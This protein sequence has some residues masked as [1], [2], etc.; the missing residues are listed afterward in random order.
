MIH[1]IYL[2]IIAFMFYWLLK[3]YS[4]ANKKHKETERVNKF[5]E[6]YRKSFI[7]FH[8]WMVMNNIK[9]SIIDKYTATFG[10]IP[11]IHERKLIKNNK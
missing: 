2:S 1:I 8:T 10:Y 5:S 6:H 3:A 11:E 4:F 7:V 9:H